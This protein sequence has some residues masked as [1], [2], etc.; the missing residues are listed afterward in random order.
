MKT[1]WRWMKR[2][3]SKEKGGRDRLGEISI[4]GKE[5]KQKHLLTGV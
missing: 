1:S 2:G 4:A 3:K 5:R